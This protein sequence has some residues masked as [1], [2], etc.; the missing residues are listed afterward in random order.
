MQ[1][2]I[3]AGGFGTRLAHIVKD[4]PK[5]LAPIDEK[6]FLDYQIEILKANGF[7]NFVFLTGY[8]SELIEQ[9]YKNLENAIFIKEETALGTGGAVLNAF[10]YL[11]DEFVVINGDTFFDIDYSLLKDFAKDKPAAIVLRYSKDISR[12]GLVEIDNDFKVL[13]F[14]EKNNLPKNQ[15]DGYI[16]GGIY[17]FKKSTLEKFNKSFNCEF[18]SMEND[19]FP[20]LNNLYA[21]PLGGM[22]IDIGVPEDYEKAQLLI[23]AWIEKQK[24]PALFID[25]DG[26]LIVNTEYPH[27]RNIQFIESTSKIVKEYVDKDYFIIIVTNQAGIAKGKFTQSQMEESFDEIRGYYDKI[28][29][30]FDD[31]IFCPYHKDGVIS[32]FT[33]ESFARKPEAGMIL[34]ACERNKIDLKNSIMIG[35]NP[36]ID[37][38]KLP[39]FKCKIL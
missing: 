4:V 12:Y 29:I 28:N 25:K 30:K 31:I 34:E 13:E 27:G 19:I 35:D 21:L 24:K 23:P 18:I 15:A 37:N 33:K 39:Y 26:T 6:P 14:K 1:A 38:I 32:E 22:F 3:L 5:S 9:E 8:K 2:I 36:E 10:K 11:Q 17:Y 20:K 16:N 7:D